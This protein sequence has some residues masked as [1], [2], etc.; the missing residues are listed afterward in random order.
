MTWSE[1]VVAALIA[2]VVTGGFTLLGVTLAGNS[3]NGAPKSSGVVNRISNST[4]NQYYSGGPA[5]EGAG[6]GSTACSEPKSTIGSGTLVVRIEQKAQGTPCWTSELSP[7]PPGSTIRYLVTYE[8]ISHSGQDNVF[9]HV[10]LPPRMSL[11]PNSTYLYNSNYPKGLLVQNNDIAD[12]GEIIG[13]YAPGGG[14]YIVFSVAIPFSSDLTCGWN[15]FQAVALAQPR[16]IA[17]FYGTAG[18]QVDKTC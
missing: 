17:D 11:I 6:G 8:N 9:I 12:G 14:A 13:G 10:T 7:V 2:A 1:Q 18:S 3:P 4:V 5:E 16:G 15:A